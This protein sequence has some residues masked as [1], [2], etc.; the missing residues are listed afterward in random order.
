[1]RCLVALK[2]FTLKTFVS[3][4]GDTI[5]AIVASVLCMSEQIFQHSN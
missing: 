4:G 1:M 3:L 5:V 2:T